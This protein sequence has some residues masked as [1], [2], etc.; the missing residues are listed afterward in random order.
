MGQR[1][2]KDCFADSQ[3]VDKKAADRAESGKP[4]RRRG[5][6]FR[7]FSNQATKEKHE[8]DKHAQV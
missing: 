5:A 3:Q 8:N 1:R 7:R 6:G 2:N 4:K